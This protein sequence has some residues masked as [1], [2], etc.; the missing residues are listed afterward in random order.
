MPVIYVR[1]N[2]SGWIS[3]TTWRRLQLQATIT[4]AITWS[5]KHLSHG[6]RLLAVIVD[7]QVLMKLVRALCSAVAPVAL[8]VIPEPG[9]GRFREFEPRRVH[10]RINSLGLFL[11]DKLTCGKRES[12]S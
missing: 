8:Q 10:T 7:I 6:K 9:M 2:G 3:C 5:K 1:E 4:I 11:V 12:V